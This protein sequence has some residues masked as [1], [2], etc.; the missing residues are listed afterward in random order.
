VVFC[1]RDRLGHRRVEE[2]IEVS[3]EAIQ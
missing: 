1:R 2:V 3:H